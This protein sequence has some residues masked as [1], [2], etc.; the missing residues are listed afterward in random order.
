MS[1]CVEGGWGTKLARASSTDRQARAHKLTDVHT[2]AHLYT[3]HTSYSSDHGYVCPSQERIECIPCSCIPLLH[4]KSKE[5]NLNGDLKERDNGSVPPTSP[6]ER[7]RKGVPMFMVG[8]GP[9]PEEALPPEFHCHRHS[10]PTE[11][12]PRELCKGKFLRCLRCRREMLVTL[13]GTGKED[14]VGGHTPHPWDC[15]H[16]SGPP[17]SS[18]PVLCPIRRILHS[19]RQ[20]PAGQPGSPLHLTYDTFLRPTIPTKTMGIVP[21]NGSSVQLRAALLGRGSG[22]PN[23]TARLVGGKD[24]LPPT[25]HTV[26]RIPI[27]LCPT[28]GPIAPL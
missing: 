21:P 13:E 9:P 1:E 7:G 26:L 8:G 5:K 28:N 11:G 25:T 10:T 12:T 15:R 2:H 20:R 3:H 4:Q 16:G 23:R 17:P 6:V 18:Q 22:P 24:P 19:H 27:Q 14:G